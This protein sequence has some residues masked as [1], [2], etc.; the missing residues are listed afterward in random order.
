[1]TRIVRP[2]PPPPRVDVELLTSLQI[3]VTTHGLRA[4][5]SA[6]ARIRHQLE[7]YPDEPLRVPMRRQRKAQEG[8]K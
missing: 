2:D 5:E 4:V 8:P 6:T 7:R 1:M 3:A